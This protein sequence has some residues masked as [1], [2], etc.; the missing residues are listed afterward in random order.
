MGQIHPGNVGKAKFLD[1]N[2]GPKT[3][4][5]GPVG[6]LPQI[7]LNPQVR[8]HVSSGES[9]AARR[10]GDRAVTFAVPFAVPRRF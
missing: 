6:T 2:P 9:A 3:A 7:G 1:S 10:S 8:D 5:D 4:G